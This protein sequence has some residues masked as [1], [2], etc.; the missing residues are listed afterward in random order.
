MDDG[1]SVVIGRGAETRG[2]AFRCWGSDVA[3][4]RL[5]LPAGNGCT[6]LDGGASYPV[7]GL[8]ADRNHQMSHVEQVVRL[9]GLRL[10]DEKASAVRCN[11]NRAHMRLTASDCL[12]QSASQAAPSLRIAEGQRQASGRVM[13]VVDSVV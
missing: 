2:C 6:D 1:D 9:G 13:T 11:V 7:T 12:I 5:I 4:G 10:L 3:H 8:P